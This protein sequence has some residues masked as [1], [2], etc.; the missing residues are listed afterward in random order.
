GGSGL[1]LSIVYGIVNN[2]G[3]EIFLETEEGRGSAF[4]VFLPVHHD[5]TTDRKEMDIEVLDGTE[6]ILVVDDELIIR[7]MVMEILEDRGYHV[8]TVGSGA[9][10]LQLLNDGK[11]RFDIILLD[12]I[13]PNMDGEATFKEIR[14][15]DADIPILM[16][17]G[18]ALPEKRDRLLASGASGII[19]K[20]YKNVELAAQ[21]R[22]I[23]DRQTAPSQ[24]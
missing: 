20:P 2:H 13:M 21:L 24:P 14:K 15:I 4:T 3:G 5:K 12:I 17:S 6:N 7:Q 23:L 22:R 16:T 9:E 10:A 19:Y 18:Y 1:G 8:T 11:T